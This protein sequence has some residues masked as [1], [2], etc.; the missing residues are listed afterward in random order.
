MILLSDKSHSK[1]NHISICHSNRH[2]PTDLKTTNHRILTYY[3]IHITA[4]GLKGEWKF[5]QLKDYSITFMQVF[6][7]YSVFLRKYHF[8]KDY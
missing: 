1:S 5:F 3:N 8:L 2:A 7:F 4:S 6:Q